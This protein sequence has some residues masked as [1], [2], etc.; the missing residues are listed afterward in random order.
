MLNTLLHKAG[1]RDRHI[2]AV[3]LLFI[4]ILNNFPEHARTCI[5]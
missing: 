2:S 4:L 1:V 3:N 5:L